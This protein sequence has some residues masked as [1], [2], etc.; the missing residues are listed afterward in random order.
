[1]HVVP[2]NTV[3]RLFNVMCAV[4]GLLFVSTLVSFP[5]FALLSKSLRMELSFEIARPYL[6]HGPVFHLFLLANEYIFMKL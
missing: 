3:E 2:F 4:A 6:E 5:N 1:M